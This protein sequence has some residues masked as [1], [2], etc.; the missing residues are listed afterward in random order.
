MALQTQPN[1]EN[2]GSPLHPPKIINYNKLIFKI[3]IPRTSDSSFAIFDV[4]SLE[5]PLFCAVRLLFF[6]G[7]IIL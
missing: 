3:I 1:R 6:G 2:R 4:S 7:I 5:F